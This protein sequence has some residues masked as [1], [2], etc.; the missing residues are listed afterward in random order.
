MRLDDNLPTNQRITKEWILLRIPGALVFEL[1]M[2]KSQRKFGNAES[3]GE[4]EKKMM[5]H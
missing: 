4:K 2:L 1:E 5:R 3:D